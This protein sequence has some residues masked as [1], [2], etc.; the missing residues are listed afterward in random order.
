[1]ET[2]ERSLLEMAGTA[3]IDCRGLFQS[4]SAPRPTET[5]LAKQRGD[6]LETGQ[7]YVTKF[8][9]F[10]ADSNLLARLQVKRELLRSGLSEHAPE[11]ER[12]GRAVCPLSEY[13]EQSGQDIPL[14]VRSCVRVIN[15][16]GLHHQGIF[17][18]SG[19][20]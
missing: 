15:L 16:Y 4:P 1:M 3:E 14:I 13:L 11:L 9:E 7:F 6:Q 19:S 20:Q 18:V 8:A 17:R 12:S 5:A 2:A 10:V